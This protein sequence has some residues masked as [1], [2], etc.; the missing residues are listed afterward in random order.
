MASQPST[1]MAMGFFQVEG[2]AGAQD[3]DGEPLVRV[4]GGV[5]HDRVEVGAV[6]QLAVVLGAEGGRGELRGLPLEHGGVGVAQGGHHGSLARPLAGPVGGEG[7]AGPQ[8]EPDD[9]DAQVFH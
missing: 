4:V 8:A 5:D 3:V 9:P 1:V 7:D 6:E 2:L